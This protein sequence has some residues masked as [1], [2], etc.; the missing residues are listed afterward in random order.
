MLKII[1]KFIFAFGI[2]YWLIAQGQLD[3][4]LVQRAFSTPLLW[5]GCAFLIIIQNCVASFRWKTLIETKSSKNLP[6]FQILKLNWIGLFFS[7]VLP[8]AVTGDLIKVVYARH[9]DE[10]LNKT[11]LV[12]SVFMDRII[13]L[14]GLLF[15]LGIFSLLNYTNIE[16]IAPEMIPVIKINLLLF[17]GSMIFVGTLFLPKGPKNLILE[18]SSKLPLIG[19]KVKQTLNDVWLLGESKMAFI[20]C[21]ALS[22]LAQALSIFAF[23]ALVTPFLDQPLPFSMAFTFIP[24]GFIAIA[25]PISP[26]GLGVGHAAFGKLFSYF[27]ITTG[28]SLFNLYFLT[29]VSMNILGIFP[30]LLAGNKK[31]KPGLSEESLD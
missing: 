3:F 16:K 30:Y 18:A 29:F 2:L 24:L 26:A 12:T 8:G 31:N 9:L 1:L 28:A 20:I 25:I 4:S 5:A 13:G 11:F 22:I 15:L 21:F 17:L 23:W 7:S 10:N 27:G 6:Y 14:I 19:N